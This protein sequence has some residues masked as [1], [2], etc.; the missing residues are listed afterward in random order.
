MEAEPTEQSLIDGIPIFPNWFLHFFSLKISKLERSLNPCNY[1][2]EW[3][4]IQ[5]NLTIPSRDSSRLL[6]V[7]HRFYYLFP[8]RVKMMLNQIAEERGEGREGAKDDARVA[9][10]PIPGDN[11]FFRELVYK[12]VQIR[13]KFKEEERNVE[14]H[15]RRWSVV[16]PFPKYSS[17]SS[18][19]PQPLFPKWSP[20]PFPYLLSPSIGGNA[21]EKGKMN[22]SKNTVAVYSIALF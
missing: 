8:A 10:P 6:I 21:S 20:C 12:K 13:W 4:T 15:S 3:K 17:F 2:S 18:C 11:A 7:S 5:W 22:A 9:T 1:K 19:I 14:L 16:S